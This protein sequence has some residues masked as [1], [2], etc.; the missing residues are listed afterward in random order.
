MPKIIIITSSSLY[1]VQHLEPIINKLKRYSELYLII[2]YDPNYKI[3]IKGL[4]IIYIPLK[5]NPSWIDLISLI[6]T[7]YHRLIIRPWA[8]LSFTAKGGALNSFTFLLGGKT[9]H[10]FTG[11][12]WLLFKGLKR[13]LF[14]FFDYIIIKFSDFLYCDG[15]SQSKFIAKELNTL[16]PKVI[17]SGSLSGVNLSL[18]NLPKDE[19]YNALLKSIRNLNKKFYNLLIDKKNKNKN[20]PF[21]FGYVGRIAKDKGILDLIT[22]FKEHKIKYPNSYLIIIGPQ[23]LDY[24]SQK[25]INYQNILYL[26]YKRDIHLY[27]NCLDTLVL[28]SYREGFGSVILEAAA[29]SLPIISTNI[30]GPRDFIRHK[31]NG[32]LVEPKNVESLIIALDYFR[33]NKSELKKYAIKALEI[34]NEKYNV[35][36]VSNLFVKDLLS[37]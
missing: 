31:I 32:Y 15:L 24:E 5:R 7:S 9:I 8:V 29:S 22:A 28:P 37:Q 30:D 20:K 35:D 18:Y 25:Q 6:L 14:K 2:P 26:G 3:R 34:V 12:R 13:K 33:D 27:F 16:P 21:L 17:G 19:S 36:Y 10:Y 4:K 23:E 11:L 1:V